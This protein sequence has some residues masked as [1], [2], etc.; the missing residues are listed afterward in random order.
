MF[1]NDGTNRDPRPQQVD[2]INWLNSNWDKS[3]I[4]VIKA[5]TGSGKSFISKTIQ[6]ATNGIILT[7]DNSLI[8]QYVEEYP[9][10]NVIA[11]KSNYISNMQYSICLERAIIGK[12]S[13][14]N[15]IAFYHLSQIPEYK[16]PNVIILDEADQHTSLLFNL[17][18]FSI[19]LKKSPPPKTLE[20]A[21]EFLRREIKYSEEIV[22]RNPDG[23]TSIKHQFRAIKYTMIVKEVAKEKYKFSIVLEEDEGGTSFRIVPVEFPVSFIKGLFN[24][25]LVLL[26]GTLFDLDIKEM[27]GDE[28]YLEY[29]VSSPIPVENRT[30]YCSPIE[31]QYMSYPTDYYT[32]A[33]YL[34]SLLDKFKDLR[35]CIIHTTYNDAVELKKYIPE[36]LIHDKNNKK[37]VLNDWLTY[38]G[39]LA[40]AG[41]STGLDL[42]YDLCRLNIIL[43]GQ[44]P[45]MGDARTLKR[46]Y[47]N[48]TGRQWLE[49]SALRH[50]IQSSGRSSRSADDYSVTIICDDRLI[51]LIN[52][53]MGSIPN[54]F[55]E[56]L[57]F[58]S[59]KFK[60]V[61]DGKI[62]CS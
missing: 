7:P 39:I 30:I 29:E 25:K 44:F 31:E 36:L 22:K 40:G 2:V 62:S 16:K 3:N 55:K 13:I 1:K 6:N 27:V 54:Y 19:P 48:D 50:L 45:S 37:N 32:V 15:P 8:K 33:Q 17:I 57:D 26:S 59:I 12:P 47:I 61:R 11:G 21:L 41:M 34:K 20:Q 28:E 42:K 56:A 53:N 60:E 4:F 49:N 35:P 38:G 14:S 43:K 24:A 9:D 18:G 23:K 58:E 46:L 51:K 52:N 10:L 5:P